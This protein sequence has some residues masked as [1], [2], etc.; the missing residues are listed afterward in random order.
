MWGFLRWWRA[1]EGEGS[2]AFRRPWWP[3]LL[4]LGVMSVLYRVLLVP[5]PRGTAYVVGAVLLACSARMV[6]ERRRAV[7]LRG[8]CLLVRPPFGRPRS[9]GLSEVVSVEHC[10]VGTTLMLRTTA[11]PGL[12]LTPRNGGPLLIPLDFPDS[13]EL[14]ERIK[15]A[16]PA[17]VTPP[18][19]TQGRSSR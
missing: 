17:D 11:G 19:V 16:L 5:A 1:G 6:A 10:T 9:V 7:I 15:A 4:A 14:V 3:L 2:V 8:E 13:E 12:R 18:A